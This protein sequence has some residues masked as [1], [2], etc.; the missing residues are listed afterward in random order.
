[1]FVSLRILTLPTD[2]IGTRETLMVGLRAAANRLP[3][4]VENLVTRVYHEATINS[5]HIVWRMVHESEAAA[6]AAMLDPAWRGA[7]LP[8]IGDAEVTGVGYRMT[9]KAP[10]PGG[11]KIWRGLLFSCF[12]HA[13][14]ALVHELEERTLLLAKYVPEIRAWGLN[15]AAWSEG[16]KPIHYVWEQEYDDIAGLTG[17][18]ME[19]PVHW[20]LVDAYFDADCPEFIVDPHLVQVVATISEPVIR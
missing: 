19:T 7:V 14:P 13:D 10:S 12:A 2:R 6:N 11:T 4:V 1:M 15:R 5:G 18:Y 20:G 17:P 9:R 8:L 16:R 3:G